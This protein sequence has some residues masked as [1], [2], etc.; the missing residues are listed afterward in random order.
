MRKLL[1]IISLAPLWGS[2]YSQSPKYVYTI[3]ADTVK[4]TNCDSAE[5]V[6]QN[7]TQGVPG[8]LFNAGNGRTV[9]QRGVVPLGSGKYLVGADTINLASNAWVQGGNTFGTTGILGTLDSNNLDF[10]TDNIRRAR[11]TSTG[12]LLLGQTSDAG[13]KL[14]VFSTARFQGVNQNAGYFPLTVQD[15]VGNICLQVTNA[16]TF[17]V[18]SV[19]N[20]GR[21]DLYSAVGNTLYMH[22]GGST[23]N[24]FYIYGYGGANGSNYAQ[25]GNNSIGLYFDTRTGV[26]PL[27]I[28]N[29]ST[30]AQEM[31]IFG[32]G[33]VGINVNSVDNGNLFQVNGSAWFGGN[34]GLGTSSPT[35]QLHTTGSVRFAG[36]TVD[37]LFNN[38]V[39]C[40]SNG[41][42]HTRS[43][44]SLAATDFPRSSLAVNGTIKAR[45]LTLHPS[46]WADFVF[47]SSY[48]L[49]ALS[50]VENYIRR[51][52][53]LPGMPSTAAVE[54]EGVDVG[55]NQAA[56]LKKV[57]ELTLYSIKQDHE[58]ET[59]K[60]EV[61]EL[62]KMITS[63]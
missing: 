24:T 32:D 10:Y 55:E 1:L 52:H 7:H 9:F 3:K 27:R 8:F 54:R 40:D 31:A 26:P 2:V 33:N 14:D 44:S 25:V 22:T 49:L 6:L 18:G 48:R 39:V 56:L 51:E 41:N 37:S 53:H 16:G 47:D 11:L 15:N 36:L 58:I 23:A 45:N 29:G 50:A 17:T 42:L 19:N 46:G 43:A 59:L 4:I 28:I 57:E 20:G 5:L 62:K 61:E 21:M 38:V 60:N 13:Y 34:V 35:A 12:D 30:L 63:K